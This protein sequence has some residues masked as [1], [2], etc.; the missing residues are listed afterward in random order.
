MIPSFTII[1]T[2]YY[3]ERSAWSS[4]NVDRRL[5]CLLKFMSVWKWLKT[6]SNR[7]VI[8]IINFLV[9]KKK[10]WSSFLMVMGHVLRK[11]APPG[12]PIDWMWAAWHLDCRR[13]RW[14]SPV[15]SNCMNLVGWQLRHGLNPTAPGRR[16]KKV[17]KKHLDMH[18]S[19]LWHFAS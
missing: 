11:Y 15:P 8:M 16:R 18:R 10:G 3:P 17:K 13:T 14:P 1:R 6:L 12:G 5:I 4:V 9:C 7:S 2:Q 19:N